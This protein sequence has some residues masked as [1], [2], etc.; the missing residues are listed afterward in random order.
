MHLMLKN[1]LGNFERFLAIHE[2]RISANTSCVPDVHTVFHTDA[3]KTW[4]YR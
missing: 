1:R 2:C 4:L 3:L